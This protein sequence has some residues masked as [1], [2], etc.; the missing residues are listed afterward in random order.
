MNL[1]RDLNGMQKMMLRWEAFHPLNAI[2]IVEFSNQYSSND[3]ESAVR[4]AVRS[5]RLRPVEFCTR[6]RRFRFID[7]DYDDDSEFPIFE[8]H[9]S[10]LPLA[11]AVQSV[12]ADELNRPFPDGIHWPWRIYKIDAADSGTGLAV[13]YQHAVTDARGASLVMREICRILCGHSSRVGELSGDCPPLAELF[14]ADFGR[15]TLMRRAA[16]SIDEFVSSTNCFRVATKPD[17]DNSIVPRIHSTKIPIAQVRDYARQCGGT[18]QD[19]LFA[20][21]FVGLE[22]LFHDDLK[23]SRRQT[24]ALRSMVD[25]RREAAHDVDLALSQVLG[26]MTVRTRVDPDATI[27]QLVQQVSRQTRAQKDEKHYRFYSAQLDL[28]SRLWDLAPEWLNRTFSPRAFPVVGMISNLNLTDLLAEEIG[29]GKICNYYRMTGNGP[30]SPMMLSATTVGPI[31]NISTT[32]HNNQFS[33]SEV[34]CFG[35]FLSQ[36]ICNAP[37]GSTLP[38]EAPPTTLRPAA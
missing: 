2:H 32:H 23:E 3:L 8:V 29:A 11:D 28:M 31:M 19:L 6:Y 30:L 37:H 18:V 5:L 22:H 7:V 26:C 21:M 14:P 12:S 27:R 33:R 25:L 16:V 9:K 36:Q 38:V 35:A 17:A 15:N 20:L 10:L 4:R 13:A 1:F 24:L 34:D